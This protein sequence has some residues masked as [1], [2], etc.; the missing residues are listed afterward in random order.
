MRCGALRALLAAMNKSS[1]ASQ[2]QRAGCIALGNVASCLKPKDLQALGRNGGAQAVTGAF[3]AC[4]GDKDVAL[5]G[6]LAVAKL[7][8]SSENRRLLGQAGV[9]PMISKELLDFSHDEAVAEGG[10]RAVTRL[11]ALSG[12]NRTALGHARAAEATATALLKHPSKP[13]VQRWGLSAAAALVAETDPSGNTDRITSAGILGLGVK[14]L[15]KFRHNPTVQAEGLKT[16][17]KVATSGKDGNDAVW[18]TGVVLTV[19]RALGLYLNDA[20]VQHWGVATMRALTGSDDR[21]DVWRR[22]GAP[23]AVV[24]TLAA[25]GRDGTGRHARHDEQGLGRASETRPCTAEES[26][27]VQFQAC[28]TAF[29]LAMSSPDARR[30][31]VRE[32]AGE[33]LAG[34]MKS[35]SSNQAALRGALATLAALSASG[36]ENRKRLHRQARSPL[37]A[38]ASAL[39]SFPE[40]RRVRCEGALTVQNLSLTPGGARAM[41]KAGVAPVIIR[42]LRTTLEESSSP[43]TNEREGEGEERPTLNGAI[44]NGHSGGKQADRDVIVYLLNGLANMAAADK[45]LS[46]FIGRHGA[47][48]A[49][50]FALEHHPRDL[51]MQASGV[52]AVRAL[53]LGGCRNVQDLA[54]LRGPSAIARAQ[55][56]FLRDREIQLAVGAAMEALCRGGNRANREALVS[57]GT[58]VLLESA[59][60]QFAS[61]AEVVSQ[62]FRALVEIVLAGAGPKTVIGA[63][64]ED[65]QRCSRSVA[66]VEE[67]PPV[68]RSFFLPQLTLTE[69]EA[70]IKGPLQPGEDAGG[71]V[72]GVAVGD[73][74]C[75]VGMVLA[76]LERN[77]CREVCLEAFAALGRLLVNLGASDSES[78]SVGSNNVRDQTCQ[79]RAVTAG[80]SKACLKVPHN[81][82]NEGVSPEGGLLQLAKVRHAVKRALKIN[83]FGDV[84]LASRGGQILTLIAVARGRALAQ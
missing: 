67:E 56:L 34:M 26:L 22:A 70:T 76:V 20:N 8:M 59:L 12:F 79:N 42:L 75:A 65:I 66:G 43:T 80:D 9:C 55:G 74:S 68:K 10:C 51:Q 64:G 23:E 50:V 24:R 36:V 45:S 35:N 73:V 6:L 16:F 53:A 29:N 30:R 11:A 3:E 54:R 37:P 19:V 83:R 17:A 4:P 38:V 62:S 40:D 78:V 46:D 71:T 57:A 31:I 52:K 41:T 15:M 27:C 21:C 5:A 13:K 48:K 58:I 44:A 61:D 49:V 69:G 47:C 63:E 14:A 2:L 18:A 60:T 82:M 7:S 28:A 32:G 39:E 77:P 84:D 81:G 33:A 72:G 25:F 1:S